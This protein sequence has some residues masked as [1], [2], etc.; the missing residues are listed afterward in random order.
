MLKKLNPRRQFKTFVQKL[1][2][3]VYEKHPNVKIMLEREK[4]LGL[5]NLDY[6]QGFQKD[7]ENVK[8]NFLQFLL[9]AKEQ[10]K[11]VVGYGAAAKGNTL[12][13]FAG[14]RPDLVSYIV[15]KNPYK[16]NMFCPGSKIPIVSEKD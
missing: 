5:N 7:V 13:N 11:T 3:G 4:K 6:I 16:Q 9:K 14:V 10:K 2:K 12:L 8:N 15:D 1:N